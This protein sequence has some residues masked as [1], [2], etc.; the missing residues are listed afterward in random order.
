[1]WNPILKFVLKVLTLVNGWVLF[2]FLS[3]ED[4]EVIESQYWILGVGSLVL[5]RWHVGFDP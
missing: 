5:G 4:K 2:Q 3:V 1:M